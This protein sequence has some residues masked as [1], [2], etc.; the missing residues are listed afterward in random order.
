MGQRMSHGTAYAGTRRLLS[1]HAPH[2]PLHIFSPRVAGAI[3]AGE[4][5]RT[6]VLRGEHHTSQNAQFC[7]DVVPSHD[8]GR[9]QRRRRGRKWHI[10]AAP[11]PAAPSLS[12]PSLPAPVVVSPCHQIIL[13]CLESCFPNSLRLFSP[14]QH[15]GCGEHTRCV[16]LAECI[17]LRRFSSTRWRLRIVSMGVQIVGRVPP[18]LGFTYRSDP[19][20]P[21]H[22][23]PQ[24][25]KPC[26]L[27]PASP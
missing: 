11:R 3:G 24:Y 13:S 19:F 20:G 4:P 7:V 9:G 14:R 17:P 12:A 21:P 10:L 16:F 26:T 18:L 8:G 6:G 23:R 25:P 15:A 2:P 5:V 22:T 27:N 1:F